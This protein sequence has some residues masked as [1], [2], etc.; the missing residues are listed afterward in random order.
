MR[1]EEPLDDEPADPAADGATM[2]RSGE[3]R[4]A[5]LYD[6]DH[7]AKLVAAGTGRGVR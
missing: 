4:V 6:H 5:H 3:A 2:D 7:A 1:A